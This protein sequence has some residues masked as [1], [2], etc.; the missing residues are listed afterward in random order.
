VAKK[1][2]KNLINDGEFAKELTT[3]IEFAEFVLREAE[4]TLVYAS[5]E[6]LAVFGFGSLEDAIG[7]YQAHQET[8]R[9]RA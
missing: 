6:E 5:L 4:D 3:D 2:F 7:A 8:K 9:K 1:R